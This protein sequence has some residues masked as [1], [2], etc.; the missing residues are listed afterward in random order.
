MSQS[1]RFH[2]AVISCLYPSCT[3]MCCF[4]GK[5]RSFVLR[6]IWNALKEG[7]AF[8]LT[9]KGNSSKIGNKDDASPKAWSSSLPFTWSWTVRS[10]CGWCPD[11]GYWIE[12]F[13]SIFYS[14][15]Q[16]KMSGLLPRSVWFIKSPCIRRFPRE[17][18]HPFFVC[19]WSL[20]YHLKRKRKN[21]KRMRKSDKIY[22]PKY[23]PML[24]KWVG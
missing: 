11:L 9:E 7:S 4:A 15:F 5:M 21:E 6:R 24:H 16:K 23:A 3:E 20:Y 12:F 19:E 17:I 10:Y 14:F 13:S 22:D 1:Y 18:S 8:S 2:F